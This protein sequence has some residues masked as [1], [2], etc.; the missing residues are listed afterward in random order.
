MFSVAKFL[1]AVL[2]EINQMGVVKT[3]SFKLKILRCNTDV[4][5]MRLYKNP[6]VLNL[7]YGY[8]FEL[9]I[10]FIFKTNLPHH[11]LKRPINN[12]LHSNVDIR[13]VQTHREFLSLSKKL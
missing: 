1:V 12:Q 8:Q 2:V 9:A 4:S 13:N 11:L 7:N 6:V 3:A 10:Y 5:L